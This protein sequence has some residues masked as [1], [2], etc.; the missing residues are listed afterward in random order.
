MGL[1]IAPDNS[2]MYIAKIQS[3]I[4]DTVSKYD[5]GRKNVEVELTEQM[6]EW[7]INEK[8]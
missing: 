2:K 6:L 5:S 1:S 3:Q 8:K 4:L 7:S